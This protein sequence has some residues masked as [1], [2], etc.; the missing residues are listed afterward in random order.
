MGSKAVTTRTK[1]EADIVNLIN[2]SKIDWNV[3]LEEAKNQI[4]LGNERAVLDIGT[5]LEKIK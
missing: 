4:S 5:A 3:I 1:D 2:N